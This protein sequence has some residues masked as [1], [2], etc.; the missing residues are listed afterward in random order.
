MRFVLARVA[1]LSTASRKRSRDPRRSCS[2]A[3]LSRRTRPGPPNAVRRAFSSGVFF[4]VR[5][6]HPQSTHTA[7]VLAPFFEAQG[8]AAEA[9][10]QVTLGEGQGFFAHGVSHRG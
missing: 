5:A 3:G 1:A 6:L 2:V 9:C 7:Q 8:L 10:R 4:A